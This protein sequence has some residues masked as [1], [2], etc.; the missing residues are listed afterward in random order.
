MM[1]TP[2][3][4]VWQESLVTITR[5]HKPIQEQLDVH[6]LRPSPFAFVHED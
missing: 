6:K 1:W 4:G 3:L 5:R 2:K